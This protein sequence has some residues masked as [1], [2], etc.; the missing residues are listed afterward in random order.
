MKYIANIQFVLLLFAGLRLTAQPAED[1]SY[2]E[3]VR[4]ATEVPEAATHRVETLAAY[5]G[6]EGAGDETRAAAIYYWVAHNIRY[7]YA[8][9]QNVTMGS[10]SDSVISEAL[11]RRLG[12]CQH[13]AELFDTLAR[14][15]GL[16]STVVFGYVKQNGKVAGIPHAWDAVK[17]DTTWYLFDPTWGA[18]Y[19]VNDR[20]EQHFSWEYFKVHPV[21]LLPTHMPF[22]PLFQ[23]VNDPID[24]NE[25]ARGRRDD[26]RQRHQDYRTG[27]GA[28]LAMPE[29]QQLPLAME[30]VKSL[31]ITNHMTRAYY[32][33]LN[34]RHEVYVANRQIDMHNRAIDMFN[35]VIADYNQYVNGMNARQGRYP[36]DTREIENLL[37]NVEAKA[38]E[39]KVLF[40]SINPPMRL[41]QTLYENQQTLNRLLLQVQK[42]RK[43]LHDQSR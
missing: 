17:L 40:D 32:S 10:F 15:M 37:Q 4:I 20:Y 28:F 5:L 14:S 3:A 26:R 39:V 33:Y 31:G 18:G 34:R 27:I 7:D 11:T 30:R 16:R 23:F 25:F 2:R 35:E 43:R 24:H 1:L 42:E 41:A 6:P 9:A 13:Y 29:E 19:V 22:D 21:D 38:R 12:V 8:A 36:N